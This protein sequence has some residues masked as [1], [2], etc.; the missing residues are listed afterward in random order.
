MRS[1]CAEESAKEA[2]D[3][4]VPLVNPIVAALRESFAP[5]DHRC[6]K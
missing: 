1:V 3:K 6:L 2:V 5:H 4:F